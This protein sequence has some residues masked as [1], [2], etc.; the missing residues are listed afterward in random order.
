MRINIEHDGQFIPHVIRDRAIEIISG[1]LNSIR[2]SPDGFIVNDTLHFRKQRNNNITPCV[3]NSANFISSR[4]QYNLAQVPGCQGETNIAGQDIDGMI[5][6]QYTGTGYRVRDKNKLLE[7]LHNYIIE[8]NLPESS[9]YTLFPMF[10][11]MYV[12]NAF[13]D[14]SHLPAGARE[15]FDSVPVNS[16]F[17]LGVEFETGNVA[18]SFRALNKLFVLFQEGHIDAGVFVTSIDKST[19]ATRIWPVSNRNGSFQELRQ[20]NYLGQVSLP[21][22]C[23]GFA[24]DGF[25]HQAPFLGRG[26][27]LYTLRST[28]TI[29][30]TGGFN[31]FIGEDGE[32]I[33]R[34][35]GIF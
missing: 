18:S 6:Q 34:P 11:G 1:C 22:L 8:K 3:M 33:L 29:D 31:I 14:I 15:L 5:V 23:I 27:E 17:R 25:H 2:T 13:Y 35:V 21:L 32:E 10:Y 12:Q 16:P 19:S 4:F 28:G 24:P 20:R 9:I 30:P 7:I 26:G